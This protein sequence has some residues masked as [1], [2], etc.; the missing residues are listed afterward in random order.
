LNLSTLFGPVR[1]HVKKQL[2]RALE[3]AMGVRLYSIRAH[4][5]EDWYDIRKSGSCIETIFDVGANIGQ[6]ARKFRDAFPKANIYCFEPVRDLFQELSRNVRG[7]SQVRCFQ[8][9][10]GSAPGV[11]KIYLTDHS[12]TSSLIEP[13]ES[14]GVEEVQMD[15]I[16]SF[17]AAHGPERIDLLKVDAEGYDLEVLKGAASLLSSARV[18][19]VLVEVGFHPGDTR[20]V[21]FDHVRE[22]LMADGFHVYGFYDQNLE[23]SGESRLRFANAC[24]ANEAAFRK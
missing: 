14:R 11:G 15:T 12:T 4:A 8:M 17:C 24:F 21:L 16:D 5:R 1:R 6:S 18:A 3:N 23:W 22:C 9:A 13:E 10:L 20:H 2:N 19:F 7:D